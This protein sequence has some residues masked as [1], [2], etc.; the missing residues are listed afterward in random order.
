MITVIQHVIYPHHTSTRTIAFGLFFSSLPGYLSLDASFHGTSSN[1]ND[2][3][4]LYS[5]VTTRT[6]AVSNI[7]ANICA[8]YLLPLS[9]Y[10]FVLDSYFS[11]S[12]FDGEP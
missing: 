7:L 2:P 6:L 1:I 5:I 11:V 12:K 10:I 4:V 8:V 3:L 9:I